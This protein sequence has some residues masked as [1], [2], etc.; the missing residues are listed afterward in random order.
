VPTRTE[1]IPCPTCGIPR[2]VT[3]HPKRIQ[4]AANRRCVDCLI[5]AMRAQSFTPRTVLVPC[6]GCGT[7]RP[8]RLT[9]GTTYELETAQQ[10]KCRECAHRRQQPPVDGRRVE[11]VPCPQC[12]T[13]R[14][15]LI[16]RPSEHLAAIDRICQECVWNNNRYTAPNTDEMAI[17]RLIAGQ[18]VRA[19]PAERNQ[20]IA[21]LTRRK[22]S[23]R[24]IAERIGCTPR[25]VERHR[26]RLAS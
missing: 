23:A 6:V 7:P 19:T 4:A 3:G 25:T 14:P 1:H 16:A 26:Q 11:L 24:A 18:P 5:T 12:S 15:L 8:I 10:R 13:P 9:K 17:A 22:L 20:A 2:P 21:Y